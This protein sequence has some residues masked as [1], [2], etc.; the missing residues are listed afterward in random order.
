MILWSVFGGLKGSASWPW[1]I[2]LPV[3]IYR[4][5]FKRRKRGKSNMAIVLVC[6][7]KSFLRNPVPFCSSEFSSHSSPTNIQTTTTTKSIALVL[8]HNR[9]SLK[10]TQEQQRII[11]FFRDSESR[12]TSV[13]DSAFDLTQVRPKAGWRKGGACW[14]SFPSPHS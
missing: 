3:H 13:S 6:P 4:I 8:V 10:R 7:A 5:L 2:S 11:T 12:P 9:C 1:D 14:A